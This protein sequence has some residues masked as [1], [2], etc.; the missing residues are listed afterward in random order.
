M[1][2]PVLRFNFRGVGKSAGAYDHGVGEQR[3]LESALQWMRQRHRLPLLLAGFSFG[4]TVVVKLLAA[5][6]PTE[7]AEAVLLGLPVDRGMLP[8]TWRWRGPKLMLS[9]D[10]DEFA[11]V[12][13]LEAYFAALAEPKARQWIAGG[14]H[15]LSGQMPAFRAALRVQLEALFTA[16]SL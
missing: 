1:G 7:V 4:A 3:D 10:Q 11:R 5:T 8:V 9:G 13:A 16:A 12:A 15:F 14:D 6:A 2:L